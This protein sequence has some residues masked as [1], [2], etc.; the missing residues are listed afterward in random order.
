MSKRKGLYSQGDNRKFRVKYTRRYLRKLRNDKLLD[1]TNESR[2]SRVIEIFRL[3][4][5]V[6]KESNTIEY[7]TC[8]GQ[9]FVTSDPHGN[10]AEVDKFFNYATGE[11]ESDDIPEDRTCLMLGDYIDRGSSSLKLLVFM[12]LMKF[13]NPKN[14]F[15]LIGNHEGTFLETNEYKEDD[16]GLVGEVISKTNADEDAMRVFVAIKQW[17]IKFPYAMVVNNT[18]YFIHGGP[19][20]GYASIPKEISEKALETKLFTEKQDK[21]ILCYDYAQST[22][23]LQKIIDSIVYEVTDELVDI[24]NQQSSCNERKGVFK[25]TLVKN[26]DTLVYGRKV[27]RIPLQKPLDLEESP[28]PTKRQKVEQGLSIPKL[29][30][31]FGSKYKLSNLLKDMTWSDVARARELE[32]D[33]TQKERLFVG[34]AKSSTDPVPETPP[35][36]VVRNEIA[37]NETRYMYLFRRVELLQTIMQNTRC[38]IFS[39]K[40]YPSFIDRFLRKNSLSL[41]VRGHQPKETLY[42]DFKDDQKSIVSVNFRIHENF[43]NRVITI[44][45]ASIGPDVSPSAYLVINYDAQT[46]VIKTY[47][48]KGGKWHHNHRITLNLR[49]FTTFSDDKELMTLVPVSCKRID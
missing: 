11:S 35:K 17:L 36:L 22:K 40:F 3:A 13:R 46:V 45:N 47:E 48:S 39:K 15:F 49:D 8:N 25:G 41:V 4:G 44:H 16:K 5:E 42:H 43:Q 24:R 14:V 1:L 7:I 23:E 21:T 38:P 6:T 19:A 37:F 26:S 10:F 18:H 34:G 33:K 27:S 2:I 31:D 30:G 20:V 9:L 28:E 29:G 32:F 12:A